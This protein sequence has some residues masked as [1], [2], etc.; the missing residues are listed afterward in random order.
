MVA[1]RPL[2]RWS[3]TWFPQLWKTAIR[4]YD[5]AQMP[6]LIAPA[7]SREASIQRRVLLVLVRGLLIAITETR[8]RA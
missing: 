5:Q 3:S 7:S 6:M 2:I 1:D 4:T 8:A